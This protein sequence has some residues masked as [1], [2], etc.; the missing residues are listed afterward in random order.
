MTP[1]S[2]MRELIAALAAQPLPSPSKSAEAIERVR[3]LCESYA[4]EP[5][6]LFRDPPGSAGR[7]FN[8]GTKTLAHAVLATIEDTLGG[9]R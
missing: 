1:G 3:R 7:A 5:P 8:A 6:A 4:A 2:F 9:D